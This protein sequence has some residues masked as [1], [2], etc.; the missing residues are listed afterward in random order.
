MRLRHLWYQL[1]QLK[2]LINIISPM[3][4][5]GGRASVNVDIY[6]QTKVL[7]HEAT[8]TCCNSH[9][10]NLQLSIEAMDHLFIIY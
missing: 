6:K 7:Q 9:N 8:V 4:E 10:P 3:W 2:A 1:E 5:A